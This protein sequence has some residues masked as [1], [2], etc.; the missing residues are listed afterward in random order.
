MTMESFMMSN[1][2]TT[3]Q[4]YHDGHIGDGQI[5]AF[6]MNHLD[7]QIIAFHQQS[8]QRDFTFNEKLH[9]RD[10][11][12]SI[13]APMFPMC[14]LYVVG[15]SLNGFGN[16]KS[17]LDL[18]LM[19]TN[20]DIDQ[21]TDAVTV[22]SSIMRALQKA[23]NVSENNLIL[24]KVPILRI[25]FSAAHSHLTVDLNANNSVAIRNTHL[26]NFYSKADC[27]RR[28]I[29]DANR[30]SFTSYSLVLM[31]I[32]YLQCGTQPPVLP[33][34][35]KLYPAV[36]SDANICRL[37]VAAPLMPALESQWK[38]GNNQ[39]F[40][41]ELL[42]GFFRYYAHDFNFDT[43]AISVRLGHR[44]NGVWW[45]GMNR[46]TITCRNGI[47]SALKSRSRCLILPILCTMNEF[48]EPSKNHL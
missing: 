2:T 13:I 31:V 18:C 43:D 3:P 5:D 1:G 6:K 12:Y 17:D 32:H 7:Q 24:A 30:S 26:L 14:G 19:V 38:S 9:L 11:L 27:R 42:L 41:G 45:Q 28:G 48:S 22:L 33:S 39:C 29:N 35:Q 15:S 46:R 16:D 23:R 25:V 36:F 44:V 4:S 37:N 20:R 47:A 10:V 8:L 34:L 21:Q 40:L